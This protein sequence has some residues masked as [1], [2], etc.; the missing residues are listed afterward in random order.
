MRQTFTML[1]AALAMLILASGERAPAAEDA[2]FSGPQVGEK[3][4]SFTVRGV[5][6]DEEGKEF[7]Y[8]KQADGKPICLIFVHE[9]T[10]PSAGVLR[11]VTGFVAKHR[12]NMNGGV[13]FLGSDA[14]ELAI[15]IK[16]A[17]HALAKETP[18]G[19]SVDGQEGPGAYG[20]NRKATLTVLIADDN[21]VTANFALVQPS[22]QADVPRIVAEVVKIVGGKT[23]TLA[24]LGAVRYVRK[25]PA[26]KAA[27][28][29]LRPLLGPVIRKTATPEEVEAA[30]KKAE[31]AFAKN[32]A[33]GRRV[34][35]VA[36]NIINSDK[37]ANYGT[38][39]AQEYLT[40]WAKQFP[41]ESGEAPRRGKRKKSRTKVKDAKD[42]SRD[43]KTSKKSE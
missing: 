19:I 15:R 39:R 31:A 22:V 18:T 40:K 25:Q 17:R 16:R 6:D 14:T 26:G 36:R 38:E 11:A 8:V 29:N 28:I 37:L 2:L 21:K 32:P 9:L 24:E 10:R 4:T 43:T 33:I 1:C 20:L 27:E 7:D 35:E 30:A 42:T 5:Y 13:V 34:G 12:E 3:L 41:E 23:P